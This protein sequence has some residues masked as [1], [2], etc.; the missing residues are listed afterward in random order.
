M[1]EMLP[2][3]ILCMVIELHSRG[4]ESLYLFSGRSPSGMNW[5]YEIGVM[6]EGEW[7]SHPPLTQDSLD[8]ASKD[9]AWSLSPHSVTDLADRFETHF[10]DRLEGARVPNP[11]YAQWFNSLVNTLEPDQ[12]LDFY[13]DYDA[14]FECALKTAPGYSGNHR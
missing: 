9:T 8:R 11:S 2:T 4:Y 12:L 14:D 5:R 13:A 3:Q 1:S 7:P 6:S 10:E